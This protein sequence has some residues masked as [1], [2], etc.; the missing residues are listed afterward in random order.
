MF[1]FKSVAIHK[2]YSHYVNSVSNLTGLNKYLV[3]AAVLLMLVP[4]ILGVKWYFFTIGN[5]TRKYLGGAM[6]ISILILYNLSLYGITKSSYFEFSKGKVLKWYA[7]TPEGIRF[8]DSPGYDPKYGIQLKA[9]TPQIIANLE[10]MKRGM[11]PKKLIYNSL[12]EIELFNQITGENK[13]WYYKDSTDNYELFDSAGIHPM[14]GEMLKPV[15]QGIILEIKAKI[16][17]DEKIKIDKEKRKEELSREVA[18]RLT[19]EKAAQERVAFLNRY[20]SSRSFTNRP[21]SSEVAVIIIDTE[22]QAN[23]DTSQK[24]ADSLKAK[25]INTTSTLFSDQFIFDGLF[26]KIFNGNSS[27][28]KKLELSKY[29]DK[30]VLGK[31][32]VTFTE[33]PEIQTITARLTINFCIIS[34]KTGSIKNRFSLSE[35]GPGFSKTAAQDMAIERIVNAFQQRI[36]KELE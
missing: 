35:V 27:E 26:E 31:S 12:D 36:G 6:I 4:F 18:K 13:V 28:I 14:Y 5:R 24:I 19:E 2:I 16:D 21:E 33:N 10:K 8:Y 25:G 15:T 11:Q 20:L 17:E 23:H 29:S 32:T 3:R 30:I 7:S 34:S 9:V 1:I 22:K